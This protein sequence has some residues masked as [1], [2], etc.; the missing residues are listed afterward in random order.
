MAVLPSIFS[1]MK[2]V[3]R[4]IREKGIENTT[5]FVTD[6]RLPKLNEFAKRS[7][8]IGEIRAM[9]N[10]IATNGTANELGFVKDPRLPKFNQF[11]QQSSLPQDILSLRNQ[12]IA[13]G[14][15]FTP[16]ILGFVKPPY[17]YAYQM[18]ER[19]RAN[20]YP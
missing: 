12:L 10:R 5:G 2:R 14:G 18:R 6:P 19:D 13:A 16:E 17:P 15:D 11:V 4:E 9:R 3:Q 20:G 1:E 8:L 7:P